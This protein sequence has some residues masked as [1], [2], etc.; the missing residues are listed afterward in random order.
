MR[1]RARPTGGLGY[2]Q[3]LDAG[4]YSAATAVGGACDHLNCH[5]G[6]F[7]VVFVGIIHHNVSV[8]VYSLEAG[9]WGPPING[10][11]GQISSNYVMIGSV[12]LAGDALHFAL[13]D[14]HR[15]LTY[16]LD[17]GALSAVTTPSLSMRMGN[18]GLVATEGNRLGVA[19]VEGYFLHLWSWRDR[20]DGGANAG[21]WEHIRII[22]LYMN[23]PVFVG[24]LAHKLHVVGFAEGT[25]T[26]FIS[27]NDGVFTVEIN[28][29][30]VRKVL[31]R[32]YFYGV[33]PYVGF[34][35]PGHAIG[36]FASSSQQG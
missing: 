23:L 6:S 25:G 24:G 30:W 17:E 1:M 8:Y 16:H 4:C 31:E 36:R 2:K 3:I 26:I 34:C 11:V 21:E 20:L 32:G 33:V 19:G 13:E 18:M 10:L 27:T 22:D 28:S 14:G 12:L 9:A 5:S 29:H 15:V 7:L 35:T